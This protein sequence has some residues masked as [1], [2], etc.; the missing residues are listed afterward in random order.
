MPDI[1]MFDTAGDSAEHG[2]ATSS[3]TGSSAVRAPL[4]HASLRPRRYRLR[5][6]IVGVILVGAVVFLLAEGIG[7][8]L[9]YF[10]TVQQAW[11]SKSSLGTSNFRLEGVVVPGTIRRTPDGADF[12]V[13]G[14]GHR[15]PV[16]NVGSPP[17]L[18]QPD[19]PVI[20]VGHFVSPGSLTFF[21]N[22]IMVK[23]SSQ[24]IASYPSRVKA[25]NGS[26]H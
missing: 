1:A 3:G 11:T 7:N 6:V 18:F 4:Q 15:I 5:L 16:V 19:I 24:Y 20:V 2:D 26:V 9:N 13:S 10:E 12:D 17:Q 23:H 21:S 14:G 22:Q 8:S 25:P